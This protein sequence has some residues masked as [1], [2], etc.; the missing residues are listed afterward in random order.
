MFSLAL[1]L[2]PVPVSSGAGIAYLCLLRVF[3]AGYA[4]ERTQKV[5]DGKYIYFYSSESRKEGREQG[6]R[7]GRGHLIK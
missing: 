4:R 6:A 1:V 2:A 3:K 5:K 7:R